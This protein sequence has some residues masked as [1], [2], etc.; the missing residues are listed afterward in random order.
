MNVIDLTPIYKHVKIYDHIKK[1]NEIREWLVENI[2]PAEVVN[3]R[4]NLNKGDGWEL[5]NE[6]YG[7]TVAWFLNI[8]NDQDAVLFRLT[9]SS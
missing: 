8:E 3:G 5:Y 7:T 1:R 6:L 2:S 9:F 4:Q